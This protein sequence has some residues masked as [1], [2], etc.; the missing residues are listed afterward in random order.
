VTRLILLGTLVL[1]WPLGAQTLMTPGEAEASAIA[2]G[3]PILLLWQAGPNAPGFTQGFDRLFSSWPKWTAQA[4]LLVVFTRAKSWDGGLPPTYP[5]LGP[6]AAS[7]ALVLWT[8]GTAPRIWTELPPILELS[9]AL[10]E[11]SGRRLEPPYTIEPTEFDWGASALVRVGEGP[12]WN[13][14]GPEGPTTW[15][16]E[17]PV[18]TVLVVRERTTGQRAA[19]PLEGDWSFLYDQAAQSWTPWSTVVVKRP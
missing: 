8:P 10:I 19:F 16:E 3:K 4:S 11:A 18:G 17:G 6:A 12:Y 14:S 5:P 2:L 7:S 15:V 1:S 9:Q 13:G